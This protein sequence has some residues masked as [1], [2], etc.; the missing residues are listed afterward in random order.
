MLEDPLQV[1]NLRFTSQRLEAPQTQGGNRPN[2]GMTSTSQEM[3]GNVAK[4]N[5][6]DEALKP[7][8]VSSRLQAN[9]EIVPTITLRT[10][11]S[12]PKIVSEGKKEIDSLRTNQNPHFYTSRSTFDD[13]NSFAR[14]RMIE[15]I[16][17]K[18][19]MKARNEF[20]YHYSQIL[21]CVCSRKKMTILDKPSV[22]NGRNQGS[23]VMDKPIKEVMEKAKDYIEAISRPEFKTFRAFGI[24]RPKGS[25]NPVEVGAYV[26]KADGKIYI[27]TKE[28]IIEMSENE[29]KYRI[30]Q[31]REFDAIA[32]EDA[33]RTKMHTIYEIKESISALLVENLDFNHQLV[34]L[35]AAKQYKAKRYSLVIADGELSNGDN[36]T[37]P[38]IGRELSGENID[39][40]VEKFK[41][42]DSQD[43]PKDITIEVLSGKRSMIWDWEKMTFKT[44]ENGQE[45]IWQ[46]GKW[47]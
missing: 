34:Q 19:I 42:L 8:G 24:I 14:G 16:V 21:E 29:D 36:K 20:F 4:E 33:A 27:S 22:K 35:K 37:S 30:F 31:T 6:R 17:L 23:Y 2:P 40:L 15:V 25:D 46:G 1:G 47:V 5:A 28:F 12:T 9:A 3:S 45:K 39:I 13:I 44:H 38:I 26:R 43:V 10:N 32:Y 18:D 11:L 41:N 7:S